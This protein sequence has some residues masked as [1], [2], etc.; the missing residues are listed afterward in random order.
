MT[1]GERLG[2]KDTHE[3]DKETV[4]LID[5]HHRVHFSAVVKNGDLFRRSIHVYKDLH[6]CVSF[7]AVAW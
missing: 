1:R 6:I 3:K 7:Q 5:V 4:F 2:E